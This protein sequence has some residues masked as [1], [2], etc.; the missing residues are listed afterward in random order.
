M[1]ES[2]DEVDTE[3]ADVGDGGAVPEALVGPCVAADDGD[4]G[5]LGGWDAAGCDEA[6]CDISCGDTGGEGP[7]GGGWVDCEEHGGG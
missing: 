5:S 3:P 4:V 7:G 2:D 6:G 1:E